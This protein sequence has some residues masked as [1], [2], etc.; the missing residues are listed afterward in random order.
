MSD[1]YIITASSIAVVSAIQ[2][3]QGQTITQGQ[4]LMTLHL[5]GTDLPIVAPKSGVITFL[6]VGLDDEVE[7]GQPLI[8]IADPA[9]DDLSQD[10]NS[11]MSN[12]ESALIAFHTRQALTLDEH[13]SQQ[14]TKRPSFGI[15]QC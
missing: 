15:S 1:P 6:R 8:E 3:N 7:T 12:V 2:V 14:L 4:L 11:V 5:M 13:R 9:E 10:S